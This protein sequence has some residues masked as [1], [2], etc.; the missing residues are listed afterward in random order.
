MKPV[1][2]TEIWFAKNLL[3]TPKEMFYMARYVDQYLMNN[4]MINNKN[5][6]PTPKEM[7]NM[8]R[9]VDQYL[10]K[11]YILGISLL[12]DFCLIGAM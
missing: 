8:A 9:Y 10:M 5:L 4:K 2:T 3:P 1:L 6:L 12:L 11:D 7:F